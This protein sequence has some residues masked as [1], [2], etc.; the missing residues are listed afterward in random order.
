MSE[1]SKTQ[2]A[3]SLML[4]RD[5]FEVSEIANDSTMPLEQCRTFI[6]KLVKQDAV[7]IID[8]LGWYRRPYVYRVVDTSKARVGKGNYNQTSNQLAPGQQTI[9]NAVRVHRHFTNLQ[10]ELTTLASIKS[11]N[12]YL[13]HLEKAGYLIRKKLDKTVSN[14]KRCGQRD[15]FRLKPA[16]DT[17]RKA[18]IF[19]REV[20][21]YDQNINT[22]FEFKI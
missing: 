8:G 12:A 10:I 3:W 1:L 22:L 6:N 21:M 7:A 17:G 11:I 15:Y 13:R 19:R 2:I 14:S 18:P 9:W 16:F 4:D 20:G 5:S